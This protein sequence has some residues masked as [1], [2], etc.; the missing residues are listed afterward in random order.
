LLFN[1]ESSNLLPPKEIE[2][3][4]FGM[5]LKPYALLLPMNTKLPVEPD[6]KN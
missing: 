6:K 5:M 2:T 1:L 4:E 3:K